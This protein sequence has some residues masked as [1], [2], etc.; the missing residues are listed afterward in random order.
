M[1]RFAF[2]CFICAFMTSSLM[3]SSCT[4]ENAEEEFPSNA[5]M[6]DTA[7]YAAVVQPILQDNCYRCHDEDNRQGGIV[8]DNYDDVLNQVNNDALL[9][10]IYGT[11]GYELMPNDGSVMDSCEREVIRAWINAGAFNN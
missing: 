4:K 7:T 2:S 6:V 11:N 10:S 1:S 9:N 3:L 8:I 5:C